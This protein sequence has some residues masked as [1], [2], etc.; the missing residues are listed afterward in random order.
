[1]ISNFILILLLTLFVCAFSKF[2]YIDELEA[3]MNIDSAKEEIDNRRKNSRANAA[4]KIMS[5][6]NDINDMLNP[7]KSKSQLMVENFIKSESKFIE[8]IM[9]PDHNLNSFLLGQSTNTT[10]SVE[11]TPFTTYLL[12]ISSTPPPTPRRGYSAVEADTFMIIFGGCFM[13]TK[14]YNDLYFLDLKFV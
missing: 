8:N 10:K 6:Y 11:Y 12:T 7:T 5:Y 3:Q 13:D 9:K 2:T 4:L 14:C 1:M